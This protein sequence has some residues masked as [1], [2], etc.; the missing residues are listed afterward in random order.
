MCA[1]ALWLG[2]LDVACFLIGLISCVAPTRIVAFLRVLTSNGEEYWKDEYYL[3]R[4]CFCF[5]AV[6]SMIEWVSYI[7]GL[8]DVLMLSRWYHIHKDGAKQIKEF[9][10]NGGYDDV[11]HSA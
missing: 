6:T 5:N 1:R 9:N 11:C 10:P 7:H 2:L 8:L 4:Q 3:M